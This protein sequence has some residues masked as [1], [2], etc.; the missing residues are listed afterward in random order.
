MGCYPH[1]QKGSLPT[2]DTAGQLLKTKQQYE[3]LMGLME[4]VDSTKYS[5]EQ[6]F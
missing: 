1:K 3:C 4:A 5:L 2:P 6:T